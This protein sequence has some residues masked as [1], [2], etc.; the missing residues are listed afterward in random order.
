MRADICLCLCVERC[1]G[2]GEVSTQLIYRSN[3]QLRRHRI[4]HNHIYGPVKALLGAGARFVSFYAPEPELAAPFPQAAQV[5]N[6][7]HLQFPELEDFGDVIWRGN[8]GVGCARVDWFTPDGLNTWG[9]G[10]LIV[11]R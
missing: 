7:A 10:R 9:D 4:N 2:C 3:D 8:G 1:A 5:G 11:L 6:F